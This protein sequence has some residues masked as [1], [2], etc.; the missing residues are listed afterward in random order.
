ML[1]FYTG[2]TGNTPKAEFSNTTGVFEL[3]GISNPE[4]VSLFY[5]QI[6]DWLKEFE[7]LCTSTG[8][9]PDNGI[10]V[11]FNLTY[12]NSAS[13]K[14]LYKVL[15]I[16]KAWVKVGVTLVV[17]WY[18]DESDD[19]MLDDGQDIAEALDYEFN[20]IPLS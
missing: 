16:I 11:N 7:Q 14:Y 1:P 9:W 15:E 3:T 12:C 8:K 6:I 2:S 20:Y 5:N 18:Y 4:N 19:K 17:N 13:S 10:T